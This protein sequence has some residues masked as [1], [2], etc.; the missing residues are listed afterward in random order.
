MLYYTK[1]IIKLGYIM[2]RIALLVERAFSA[3]LLAQN[4]PLNHWSSD[5]LLAMK[6]YD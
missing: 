2:E 3:F 1:I 4:L 6:G 5:F